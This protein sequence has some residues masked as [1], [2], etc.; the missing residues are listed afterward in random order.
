MG[1]MQAVVKRGV[2]VTVATVRRPSPRVDEVVVRVAL[3][4]ICRTDLYVA[5]GR[6]ANVPESLVL[7]HE[8]SGTVFESGA[9]GCG[10]APGEHVAVFPIVPCGVCVSCRGGHELGCLS[11]TMLG[12]DRDGAFAEYVA[13]P[14]R[15]VHR[16]PERVSLRHAAYAEPVAAALAVLNAELRPEQRGLIYGQNRFALLV[17]RILLLHGFERLTVHDPRDRGEPPED[18]AYDFV[19][20]TCATAQA[21]AAMVRAVRPRGT[22]VLK[23]RQPWP[24]AIDLMAAI[25]KE[26]IFR[27]V[28]YGPFER[29]LALLAGGRLDLDDLLG[30]VFPL[31]QAVK[32]FEVAAAGESNKVFLAAADEHV[33]DR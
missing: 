22:V 17:R 4:G 33:R 25:P 14:S 7:G 30:P 13:V 21:L 28:N 18:H 10:P 2:G 24:A 19:I 1:M 26:T 27:A 11:R 3:A 23:S 20:E 32:A 5:N 15:C 12:V 31:E 6:I 16:L 9:G 8:F 29:A